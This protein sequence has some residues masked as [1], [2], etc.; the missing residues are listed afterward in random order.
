MKSLYCLLITTLLTVASY[1]ADKVTRSI[2]GLEGYG[3][4]GIV[5]SIDDR[6]PLHKGQDAK[7]IKAK[8]ELQLKK[9]GFK[10]TDTSNGDYIWMQVVPIRINDVATLRRSNLI[11]HRQ[12]EDQEWRGKVARQVAFRMGRHDVF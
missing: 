4:N 11:A 2:K 9:A 10:I 6:H 3:E 8:V 1:G 7:A 12:M 5:V